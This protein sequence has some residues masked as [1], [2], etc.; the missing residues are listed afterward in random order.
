MT[1]PNSDPVRRSGPHDLLDRR[2]R[3]AAAA[4]LAAVDLPQNLTDMARVWAEAA[5]VCRGVT[6]DQL[7]LNSRRHALL[8]A[9]GLIDE[10]LAEAGGD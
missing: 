5:K 4:L 7:S 3:L 10:M 8:K 2:Q 6:I 9:R 1:S